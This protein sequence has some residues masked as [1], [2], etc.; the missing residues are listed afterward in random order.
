[1]KPKISKKTFIE[2]CNLIKKQD[3]KDYKFTE[4]M[5]S[6]LDGRFVPMMNE[7]LTIAIEKLVNDAFYDNCDE[8]WFSWFVY[9]NDFG[10]KKLSAWVDEKEYVISSPSNFYDFVEKWLEFT[11]KEN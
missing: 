10:K 2:I 4:F 9:E 11:Y 3:E 6:Y 1:M 7:Y 5:E 8:S